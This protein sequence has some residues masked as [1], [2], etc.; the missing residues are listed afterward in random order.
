LGANIV[1]L[2]KALLSTGLRC[3][4]NVSGG[5]ITVIKSASIIIGSNNWNKVT[6]SD[7]LCAIIIC[8]KIIIVTSW[9][10]AI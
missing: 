2:N 7:R 5:G 8:A 6:P 10:K 1:V 4:A 9:A 3:V